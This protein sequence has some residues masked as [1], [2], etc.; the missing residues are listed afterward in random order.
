MAT[1]YIAQPDGMRIW[2]PYGYSTPPFLPQ[3]VRIAV[4]VED[5]TVK[6]P[7]APPAAT[8]SGFS[9]T[10]FLEEESIG[11]IKNKWLALGATVAGMFWLGRK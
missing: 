5:L 11:G 3:P 4:P 2:R 1:V 9:L 8:P 10:D 7:E 6:A